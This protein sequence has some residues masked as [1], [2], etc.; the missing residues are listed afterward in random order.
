MKGIKVWMIDPKVTYG[1][2]YESAHSG[3]CKHVHLAV[4]SD[5]QLVFVVDIKKPKAF[6]LDFPFLYWPGMVNVEAVP[7]SWQEWK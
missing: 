7:V 5:G 1:M 4:L 3:V 2:L 6:D